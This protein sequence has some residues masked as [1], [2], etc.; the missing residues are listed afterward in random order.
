M[1][2]TVRGAGLVFKM[3]VRPA[4]I[5]KVLLYCCASLC[6]YYYYYYYYYYTVVALVS[7]CDVTFFNTLLLVE[8]SRCRTVHCHSVYYV[9]SFIHILNGSSY[10]RIIAVQTFQYWCHSF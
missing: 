6:D 8:S 3:A 9:L 5:L 1:L 7:S 4:D 2:Q 10:V